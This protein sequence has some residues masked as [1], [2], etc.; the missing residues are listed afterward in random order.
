MESINDC[1]SPTVS[2]DPKTP[3]AVSDCMLYAQYATLHVLG[4]SLIL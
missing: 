2:P 1:P 4:R 3:I